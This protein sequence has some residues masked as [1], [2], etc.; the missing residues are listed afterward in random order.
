MVG[1][2][3]TV[4][5]SIVV[6][7][8]VASVVFTVHVVAIVDSFLVIGKGKLGENEQYAFP[9]DQNSNFARNTIDTSPQ[10]AIDTF[11]GSSVFGGEP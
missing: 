8:I 5:V 9:C 7:S 6:A 3:G 2:L 1:V 11:W 4:V 10:R